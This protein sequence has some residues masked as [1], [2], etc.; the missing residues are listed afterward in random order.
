MLQVR[1]FAGWPGTIAAVRIASGDAHSDVMLKILRTELCTD[2]QHIHKAGAHV[3]AACEACADL[4]EVKV[5][6]DALYFACGDGS[7]LKVLEVQA[8]GKKACSAR[9]FCNGM[10]GK[11]VFITGPC[12]A[13]TS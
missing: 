12:T 10:S 7:V 11:R 8:P 6:R 3:S 5:E 9:D 2:S 4:A 1:G 13:A